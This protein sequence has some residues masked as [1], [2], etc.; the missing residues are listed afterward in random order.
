MKYSN[1]I[2]NELINEQMN[3]RSMTSISKATA[4]I[5]EPFLVKLFGVYNTLLPLQLWVCY[6]MCEVAFCRHF[7]SQK[8]CSKRGM[9]KRKQRERVTRG[10]YIPPQNTHIFKGALH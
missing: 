8:V 1:E 7:V 6:C 9:S 3:Y 10:P 5:F 2:F 4:C